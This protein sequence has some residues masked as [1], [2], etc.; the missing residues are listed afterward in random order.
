MQR[1]H[2]SRVSIKVSMRRDGPGLGCHLGDFSGEECVL[3]E[4]DA[5]SGPSQ[6]RSSVAMAAVGLC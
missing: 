2:N 6:A 1:Q 3:G 5:L 4:E